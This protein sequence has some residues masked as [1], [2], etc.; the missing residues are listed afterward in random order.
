MP[1]DENDDLNHQP[2]SVMSALSW[3]ARSYFV[4][5]TYV[6][7]NR[8]SFFETNPKL[9]QLPFETDLSKPAKISQSIFS[10]FRSGGGDKFGRHIAN[11]DGH[12]RAKR[13]V[14]AA[15]EHR[16]HRSLR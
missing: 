4:R 2:V 9:E 5:A 16:T 10:I 6:L 12:F 15:R 1:L 11:N 13:P 14:D 8:S 3:C 7:F